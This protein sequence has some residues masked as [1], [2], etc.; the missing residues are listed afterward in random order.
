MHPS[1]TL[2]ALG[3]VSLLVKLAHVL[4]HLAEGLPERLLEI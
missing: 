3:H 1:G 4:R 2:V